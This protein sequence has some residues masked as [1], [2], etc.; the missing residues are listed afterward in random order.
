VPVDGGGEGFP[1]Q[2]LHERDAKTALCLDLFVRLDIPSVVRLAREGSLGSET[3]APS[4]ASRG[5]MCPVAAVPWD[6]THLNCRSS[7][8]WIKPSRWLTAFVSS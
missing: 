1:G 7:S 6:S 2:P 5:C 8:S 3:L 4:P